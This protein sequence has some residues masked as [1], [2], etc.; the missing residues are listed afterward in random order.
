MKKIYALL[1]STFG[2]TLGAQ[3]AVGDTTTIYAHQTQHLSW[4]QNY[5][6]GVVFPDGS[7]SY[8]K[9]LMTFTLGKYDCGNGYNPATAG[10]TSQ[11][12]SGWCADWDY[13]LHIMLMKPS[14]D[15]LSLGEVIT[16]YANTTMPI[17]PWSWKHD[18]VYDVTD[19][20]PLLKDSATMRIFYAGWSGGFTGTVKFEFIEG[21]P[22]REVLGVKNLWGGS[23]VEFKYGDS[24][25][26]N[27]MID[28]KT[29]MP[30]TGTQFGALRT[31]I[32]GHGMDAN[33]CSEFCSKWYQLMV[34]GS[35]VGQTDIWKSNCGSNQLYPQSG[36]WIYDRGNWCPGEAVVPFYQEFP[37]MFL[38]SPNYTVDLNFQP[39]TSPQRSAAYKISS[40]VIY[41]GGWNHTVDASLDKILSPTN[42]ANYYRQNAICGQPEILVKNTGATTINNITFNYGITGGTPQT[43]THTINLEANKEATIKLPY[44]SDLTSMTAAEG[45]FNV[46]I[47]KVNGAVDEDTSNN[48]M[49]SKF[50][51]SPEWA[52]GNFEITLKT[53]G[54]INGYVNRTNWKITNISTGA[55]VD[56]REINTAST[57]TVDTVV[58]PNGCY[59]IEL[60]C[61]YIGFGLRNPYGITN[62]GFFKIIDRNTSQRINLEKNR[63]GLASS[64]QGSLEGWNGNGFTQYFT[65]SSATSIKDI[66]HA[67]NLDIAPN[68]ANNQVSIT[69]DGLLNYKNAKI[70]I[71]NA[72]GQ[73]VK[74]LD[75]NGG[76]LNLNTTDIPSGIYMINFNKDNQQ[77]IQKLVITH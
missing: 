39:Y 24:V 26:I 64:Y 32:S 48:K 1:L 16:P 46:E 22:P 4:Y 35:N 59:K 66:D 31:I 10:E 74:S 21:T 8:R 3:A 2:I 61:S 53:S 71:I 40:S 63:D 6:T 19:F 75:Y 76:T 36:T 25:S 5:D 14:G 47:T 52:S 45:E 69:V 17:F 50:N 43:Y 58:I 62:V 70:N 65:V 77:A 54:N 51:R 23:K 44:F 18:Y 49:S 29:E 73:T 27:D 55:V 56:S 68:P 60:D 41:Y 33:G 37:S 38:A 42:D 28:V 72:L 9:V 34:N 15:T 7:T 13:D 12:R 11:G 20:Y 57:T 67:I 30:P